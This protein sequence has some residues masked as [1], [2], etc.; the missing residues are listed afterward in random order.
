MKP[1]VEK[2]DCF[3]SQAGV[4][5]K[6][7]WQRPPKVQLPDRANTSIALSTQ[8]VP[9]FYPFVPAAFFGSCLDSPMVP[10]AIFI[11]TLCFC[12]AQP[13]LAHFALLSGWVRGLPKQRVYKNEC[14]EKVSG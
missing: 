11:P 1:L 12:V 10:A 9:S 6:A 2:E 4:T 14:M 5:G 3:P 8:G 13:S 7:R